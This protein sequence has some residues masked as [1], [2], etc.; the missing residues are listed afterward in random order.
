MLENLKYALVNK[1]TAPFEA[2]AIEP[3]SIQD[4][5]FSDTAVLA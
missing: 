2:G 4:F 1:P 3:F 5:I